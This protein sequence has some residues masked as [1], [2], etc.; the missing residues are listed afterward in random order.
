M[1]LRGAS[2]QLS[3]P[4][5]RIWIGF[6]PLSIVWT[7]IHVAQATFCAGLKISRGIHVKPPCNRLQPM[8]T[9]LLSIKITV[10]IRARFDQ[11]SVARHHTYP[12]SASNYSLRRYTISL[13]SSVTVFKTILCIADPANQSRDQERDSTSKIR[14]F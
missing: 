9:H 2:P 13:Q 3:L 4:Y 7:S 6:I 8:G 5:C 11:P 12:D 10:F 14:T 1:Q